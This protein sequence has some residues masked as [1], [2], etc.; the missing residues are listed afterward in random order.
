MPFWRHW[1]ISL[2][3]ILTDNCFLFLLFSWQRRAFTGGSILVNTDGTVFS[4][5]GLSRRRERGGHVWV[6]YWVIGY[7]LRGGRQCPLPPPSSSSSSPRAWRSYSS[8]HFSLFKMDFWVCRPHW[9][10]T[11]RVGQDLTRYPT[12]EGDRLPHLPRCRRYTL[13]VKKGRVFLDTLMVDLF[14]GA[15]VS[16]WPRLGSN[17]CLSWVVYVVVRNSC[18]EIDVTHS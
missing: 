18:T 7:Y 17:R 12:T 15:K 4:S 5:E 8:T 2:G 3:S 11:E 1:W 6:G 13:A 9:L 10:L 16:H 14:S